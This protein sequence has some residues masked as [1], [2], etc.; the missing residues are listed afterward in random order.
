MY[1]DLLIKIK[2]AQA[3]NKENVKFPYSK[4]NESILELLKKNNY[5]K[6]VEKK[7]KGVKRILDIKLGYENKE[8]LIKD[9]K[10]ISKP[11]R[12]L[13]IGYKDIRPVKHGYGLLVLSTPKGIMTNKEARKAKVGGEMLFQIW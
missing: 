2:N 10:L 9:I 1:I 8:G 3:V 12:R 5:I 13:Y 11:S 6:N 7:G 4:I